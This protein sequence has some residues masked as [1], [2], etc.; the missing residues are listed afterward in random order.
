[1][2][3]SNSSSSLAIADGRPATRA[4][5]SPACG[6]GADLLLAGGRRACSPS[7]YFWQRVPD[8]LRTDRKLRHVRPSSLG[9][10]LSVRVVGAAGSA[11]EPAAGVVEPA[12]DGAVDDVVTDLDAHAADQLGVDDDVEVDG[13]VVL[14]GRAPR[15]AGRSRPSPSCAATRT[16]ATAR[17]AH[18]RRCRSIAAQRGVDRAVRAGDRL[19]DQRERRGQRLALEQRVEQRRLVVVGRG[20]GR[21][22]RRAARGLLVDQLRRT[23]NSSSPPAAGRR[24]RPTGPAP[25][26]PSRSS[27]S[28]RSRERSSAGAAAPVTSRAPAS[29][30]LPENMPRPAPPWP[31]RLNRGV[32]GDAAQR[33]LGRAAPP[34]TREQ[35]ARRASAPSSPACSSRQ[36]DRPARSAPRRRL[37]AASAGPVLSR[38]RRV[39]RLE[40]GEEPVDHAALR[41]SSS[42]PRPRSGRPASVARLPT[43]LRSD[44]TAALRSASIWACACS[45]MRSASA[46]ACSRASATICGALLAGL[47]A[48]PRRLVP[49]V[50]DLRLVL[51]PRPCGRRPWPRRAPRTA[52]RIASWRAVI[53]LL[54]GGMTYLARIQTMIANAISSTKK[55]PLGTRKL[56]AS[57]SPRC[58]NAP[59]VSPV[60]RLVVVARC[61][62]HLPRTKTN[63]AMNARLMKNIASTRPTVRKKIV[64]RRPWASG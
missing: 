51:R 63:S 24:G 18:R 55:V 64:C 59:S 58:S 36:P 52:V 40:V 38:A 30:T 7:T 8:L 31:S 17:P 48:D 26:T 9:P 28:A 16:V 22:A 32:G 29:S 44:A 19:L 25:T 53:A 39:Q 45:T 4:M 37:R 27:T 3:S 23:A 41:S 20:P 10:C 61:S 21:T 47:L 49:G 35:L 13:R 54:I 2:P 50:G 1:M 56:L 11:G 57:G 34:A 33:R 46:C 42:R 62:A 43:S 60:F 14:P 6:D 15:R 5:P 12:G